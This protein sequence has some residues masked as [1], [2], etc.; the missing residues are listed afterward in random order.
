[1]SNQAPDQ[2][3]KQPSNALWLIGLGGVLAIGIAIAVTL[4]PPKEAPG[5]RD[6]HKAR[7]RAAYGG[8]ARG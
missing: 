8:Y 6:Y 7:L 2:Q 4:K 5:A 1:M 3:I